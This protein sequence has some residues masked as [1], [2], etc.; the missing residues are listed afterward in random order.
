MLRRA[1]TEVSAV[2]CGVVVSR[3]TKKATYTSR[4]EIGSGHRQATYGPIQHRA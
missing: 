3:W 2:Q 4:S 1:G